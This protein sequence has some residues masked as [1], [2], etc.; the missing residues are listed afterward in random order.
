MSAPTTTSPFPWTGLVTLSGAIF[1]AVTSEFLPTGLLPEMAEGLGVSQSAIGLLVTVFAAT[2]VVS[3][4]PLANLTRR[5]PRKM[6][7]VIVLLVFAASN[8]LSALAPNYEVVL[9]SRVLGG[10]AH[11]LFWAVAGAY[12]GHLVPPRQLARA[13]AV[14]SG[15]V[16]VAFVLGVPTGTALGHALGWRP[17]FTLIG[18]VILVLVVFVLKFLPKVDHIEPLKTGEIALPMRKDPT[19]IGIVL[20]C[21]IT[22]ILMAGHNIFYT[23]IVPYFTEIN[24]FAPE[25]VSLLLLTYGVAG[26]IGLFLVGVF[27]SRFPRAGLL[28]GVALAVLA[29]L[30][31]GLLP[32]VWGVVIV[33]L[34]I[35]G[36]ALGGTPALLQTR[37]LHTASRRLRDVS[38]AYM[39]TSFNVGIGGGAL[40]G[41]LLLDSKGLQPLPFAG[42]AVIL[43]AVLLIVV[44]ER[45][46]RRRAA[47]RA[48]NP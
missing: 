16:S 11:G 21:T 20:I 42:A 46:I 39:T 38:I 14:T 23:Y 1:V 29:V 7:L 35:W 18:L 28:G 4:A 33:A 48:A 37:M 27:G 26:V 22:M 44:S 5:V 6:L 34:V 10:L 43:C 15:G 3:V 36:A 8:F 12:P 19:V 13:V 40:L 45:V 24:G 31:I 32:T 41:S 30:A 25:S 9:I 17:A 2:V 47:A